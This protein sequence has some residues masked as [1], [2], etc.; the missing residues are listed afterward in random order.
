MG[1]SSIGHEAGGTGIEPVT[2]LG[3]DLGGAGAVGRGQIVREAAVGS[4]TAVFDIVPAINATAAQTESVP[5]SASIDSEVPVICSLINTA[6]D[7]RSAIP[8]SIDL[9]FQHTIMWLS[10]VRFPSTLSATLRR[11]PARS[12]SVSLRLPRGPLPAAHSS[13][14]HYGVDGEHN[15]CRCRMTCH[16]GR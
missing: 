9:L 5:F 15:P 10:A 12:K 2:S 3:R 6:F 1:N 7:E 4:S 14:C 16:H 13:G 11:L 8:A